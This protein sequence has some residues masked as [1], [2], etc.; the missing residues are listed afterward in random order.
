MTFAVQRLLVLV[1]S[2]TGVLFIDEAYALGTG[3]PYG[4]E[5]ITKLLS[6]VTVC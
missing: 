6:M 5:A 4:E 3:G 2:Q 1:R